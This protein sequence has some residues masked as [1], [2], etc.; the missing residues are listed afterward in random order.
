MTHCWFAVFI[1]ALLKECTRNL[2]PTPTWLELE[3][4]KKIQIG[5]VCCNKADRFVKQA[6][7]WASREIS[8]LTLEKTGLRSNLAILLLLFLSCTPSPS[9]LQILTHTSSCS[10]ALL[11]SLYHT[12][13]QIPPTHT[14]LFLPYFSLTFRGS[15]R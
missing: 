5:A 15:T 12:K 7:F 1:H 13:P 11:L 3:Y 6:N 8:L 14:D 4:P 2:S 10:L 9:S